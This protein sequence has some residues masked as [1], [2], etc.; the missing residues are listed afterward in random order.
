MRRPI[1]W[2][3][4]ETMYAIDPSTPMARI[5]SPVPVVNPPGTPHKPSAK[6]DRQRDGSLATGAIPMIAGGTLPPCGS[7]GPSVPIGD[8]V[9]I[10]QSQDRPAMKTPRTAPAPAV[11]TLATLVCALL[12]AVS[13]P[14]IA[15]SQEAPAGDLPV[16]VVLSTGGTIASLYDPERG[17]YAP[18]LSGEEFISAVPGIADLARLEVE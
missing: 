16:V 2:V 14:P 17:G 1:S 9:S 10:P 8:S 7:A 5:R 13:A 12:T 11:S 6:M 4:P 3:R 15:V 18:A